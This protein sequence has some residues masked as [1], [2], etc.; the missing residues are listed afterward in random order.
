MIIFRRSLH[1]SGVCQSSGSPFKL[2]PNYKFKCGLEIHTQLK[3]KYKLFSLSET[4]FNADPNS[5]ISY[6]DIGLPGAQPKLNPEALLLALKA[7]SALN[8]QISLQSKFDRKHYFYRDQPLGYQVTQYYHPLAANGHVE[9]NKF[10][11]NGDVSKVIGIE[12]IQIEQDTGKLHY[13][14]FDGVI[15][16]DYNRSNTPLIEVITK[17]DFEN[18][19][20]VEVFLKNYQTLMRHMGV[21]SGNLE[22]GAIRVDVNLSVNGFPR[23]EMKNLASHGEIQ[24]AL[25]SEYSRQV[26]LLKENKGDQ[27]VQ[28]T[29]GFDGKQTYSQRLKENSVDYRY[30]PDSE[31]PVINLDKSIAEEIR[32]ILPRTPTQIM[33]ELLSTYQLEKKY[34]KYIIDHPELLKYYYKV[35]EL[36]LQDQG[37]KTNVVNNWFFHEFLGTFTKLDMKVNIVILPAHKLSEL[38]FAVSSGDISLTSARLLLK[39]LILEPNTSDKSIKELIEFYELGAPSDIS[40]TDLDK[41]VTEVCE[42]VLLESA[43]STKSDKKGKKVAHKIKFLIGMAMRKTQGRIKPDVLQKK[44]EELIGKQ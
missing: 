17:P 15:Q 41:A 32:R 29:R 7:A 35:C 27:I 1:Y 33:A 44:F 26:S 10:D 31:L 13:D 2:Y 28:E 39:Q 9:L 36:V 22:T 38:I 3:T 16:V 43:S 11:V 30:M 25:K 24:E 42:A 40:A 8:C 4:S 14:K 18:L 34:A 21:C 37:I 5:K 6:F 12:Q 23:V 20:Q 19:L